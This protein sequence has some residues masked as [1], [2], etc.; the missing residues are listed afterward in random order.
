MEFENHFPPI[1]VFSRAFL[2]AGRVAC[3]DQ[4]AGRAAY[5]QLRLNVTG[6]CNRQ[7]AGISCY[8]HRNVARCPVY[9]QRVSL[10]L[11]LRMLKTDKFCKR[12]ISKHFPNLFHCG[13]FWPPY[14][15]DLNVGDFFLWVYLKD[16]VYEDN[17]QTLDE[18]EMEI[19]HIMLNI[20][21]G[22]F[23]LVV[24]MLKID[25]FCNRL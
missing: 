21:S 23:K 13:W 3:E 24:G 14:S 16:R 2:V 8:N 18:L 10:V 17:L 7:Q 1:K 4:D 22:I 15:P 12:F 19:L 5:S 25:N 11:A 9:T 20:P 6:E